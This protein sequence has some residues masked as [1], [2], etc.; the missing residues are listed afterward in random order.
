M[1]TYLHCIATDN[2]TGTTWSVPFTTRDARLLGLPET[3]IT[4]GTGLTYEQA[5]QIV[6]I[7]NRAQRNHK[8]EFSYNL[9]LAK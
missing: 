2:A 3:V 1:T 7:D 9:T 6:S 8:N 4:E 5:M